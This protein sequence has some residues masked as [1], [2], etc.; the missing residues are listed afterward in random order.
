MSG[1]SAC[2]VGLFAFQMTD[3]VDV[4]SIGQKIPWLCQAAGT[5]LEVSMATI[6]ASLCHS[7]VDTPTK[8][9]KW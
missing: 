2:G 1:I 5:C 9:S 7:V 4:L 3:R 8:L 6:I